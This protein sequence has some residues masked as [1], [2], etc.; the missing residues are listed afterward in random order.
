M[1]CRLIRL[2]L[3]LALIDSPGV[4]NSN[5]P[6]IA[7]LSREDNLCFPS[8]EKFCAESLWRHSQ[9]QAFYC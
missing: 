6:V 5:S 8:L 7:P 9:N 1:L 3:Y 2:G 4:N